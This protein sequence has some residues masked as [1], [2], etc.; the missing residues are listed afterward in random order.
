MSSW[1]AVLTNFNKQYIQII[2][3]NRR[4]RVP[5]ATRLR[6]EGQQAGRVAAACATEAQST[7]EPRDIEEIGQ[8][9]LDVE[10]RGFRSMTW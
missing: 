5:P 1:V 9:T 6:A 7:G 2:L 3:F 4:W 10:R 8:K